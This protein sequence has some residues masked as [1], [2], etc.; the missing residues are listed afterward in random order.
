[1]Y[2]PLPNWVAPAKIA[3]LNWGI[4]PFQTSLEYS[5]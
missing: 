4:A 3:S 5:T 1:M 2:E